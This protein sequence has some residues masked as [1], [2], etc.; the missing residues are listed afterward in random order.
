MSKKPISYPKT[1]TGEQLDDYQGTL[2][3]DPYRWLEDVDSQETLDWIKSQ[4]ELTFDYLAQI[5][6]REKLQ[7]TISR[8]WNFSRVMTIH[9]RGNRYFQFRNS[10]LQNQD[11]MYVMDSPT[12][13]GHVLLDPNTLSSDGTA[14]LNTW[15]VS[16]D[17]NWLAYAISQSGSDWVEWRV[18]N[19]GSGEDLLETLEWSKFSGAA[20]AH[21]GSGFYYCRYAAP[22]DGEVFQESNYNQTIHFHRLNTTQSDDTL[23]YARPDQPEWGFNPEIT[24]DGRFLVIMVTQGTD[25]RNRIFF[26][27][28]Q[29]NGDVIEL[30]SRLEAAYIFIGNNG[31]VLYFQT[32]REAPKGRLIAIDSK[33]PHEANWKTIIPEGS[34][35]LEAAT[36]VNNQFVMI[37]LQDAHELIERFTLDGTPLGGIELP[38][39][40]SVTYEYISTLSGRKT[41]K[42]MF[43]LFHSFAFPVTLFR[44][45]F[46]TGKNEIIFK[47]DIAF[48]FS[49]YITRQ[50]FATSKDGTRVPLSSSTGLI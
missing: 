8:L 22:A 44:Y 33:S 15:S 32:D 35:T 45:D 50:V 48:D 19:V 37:F 42:E 4:N 2:V 41:D 6:A 36:I 18:R 46:E 10:G 26:K 14:A 11:V 27:D 49:P 3:A 17:G 13:R 43:Y 28:L 16:E 1:R 31:P 34:A 7:K 40:G 24:S 23:I 21:D 9:H 25:T 20:W 30:I 38:T 39:L 29:E 5:P 12:S 47:P